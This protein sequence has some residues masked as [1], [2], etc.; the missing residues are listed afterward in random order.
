MGQLSRYKSGFDLYRS[1]YANE[2]GYVEGLIAIVKKR[3]IDLVLPGHNDT[4]I[5][6][7][8]R[9]RLP[10]VVDALLPDADH[11]ALFNNKSRAYEFAVKCGIPVPHRFAY[12]TLADLRAQLSERSSQ[13]YVVKLLTSNSAKGVFHAGSAKEALT[14]VERLIKDFDLQ[15]ARFPQVEEK[16]VGDGWGCSTLYWHGVPVSFFSHRRLREKIAT[17]GTSTLREAVANAEVEQAAKKIFDSIGWHGLAMCEF[18]VCSDTGKF[19]FIEVNPRMWGSI[20]LAIA[21]GVEFPYL[22]WL[23]ATQGVDAA[24]QYQATQRVRLGW[25]ARWLLGDL[26]VVSQQLLSGK[27][28]AAYQTLL[29]AKADSTDDF[30]WDDPLV[31][32]GEVGAYIANSVRGGSLNPA[33]KGMIG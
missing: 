15:E 27:L 2:E 20:P 31:F 33:E 18:K 4:E 14:I 10:Q 28:S 9:A 16:V 17:G 13:H 7:R 30:F 6:A 23:C 24:K 19:W 5:L 3:G 32:F 8:H 25:R 1:H 22:A 29:Q 26:T 11:C 21:A 12:K